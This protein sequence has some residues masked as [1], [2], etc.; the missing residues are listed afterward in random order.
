MSFDQGGVL[1]RE[2]LSALLDSLAEARSEGEGRARFLGNTT[3]ADPADDPALRAG[4]ER[5]VEALSRELSA[6]FQ[7]RIRCQVLGAEEIALGEVEELCPEAEQLVLV[8][9]DGESAPGALVVGRS[10]FFDWLG[11]MLGGRPAGADE[12]TPARP[13]TAIEQRMLLQMAAGWLQTLVAQLPGGEPGRFRVQ[14]V[15]P[16]RV[17]RDWPTSRALWWSVEVEGL[18]ELGRVRLAW[19]LSAR[20]RST[21]ASKPGPPAEAGPLGG[22][23]LD[24]PVA[25]CAEVGSVEVPLG[26]LARMKAG[27]VLPLDVREDGMLVVRIEGRHKFDAIRGAVG[28]NAAIQIVGCRPPSGGDAGV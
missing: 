25:L 14:G 15:E 18:G 10:L 9:F 8:G 17:L 20:E 27:D 2:E 26:R 19:P 22:L 3:S 1:T 23:L 13:Y 16:V 6:T 5:G 12:P 11:R 28:R 7:S 24:A 21:A 4:M